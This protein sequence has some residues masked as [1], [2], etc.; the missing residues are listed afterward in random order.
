[1]GKEGR[2]RDEKGEKGRRR[3]E[4]ESNGREGEGKGVEGRGGD[5]PMSR[6]TF[7]NVPTPLCINVM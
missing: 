3:E 1:M 7:L 5:S 4:R 2:E 6:P